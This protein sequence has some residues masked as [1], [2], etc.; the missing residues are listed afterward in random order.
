MLELTLDVHL[1]R[2]RRVRCPVTDRGE[3][4][5]PWRRAGVVSAGGPRTETDVSRDSLTRDHARALYFCRLDR[6]TDTHTG[7]TGLHCL[8]YTHVCWL[9]F[10]GKCSRECP[11]RALPA[12][13]PTSCP[14]LGLLTGFGLVRAPALTH[15][16]FHAL[17]CARH[18]LG[19][20]CTPCGCPKVPRPA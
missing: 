15:L 17:T 9:R 8:R 6:G 11:R 14:T 12:L 7:A 13:S 5:R 1:S 4:N 18:E 2:T 16:Y 10:A 20:R 3:R 19:T